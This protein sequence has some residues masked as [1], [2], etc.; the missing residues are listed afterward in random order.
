M[1]NVQSSASRGGEFADGT[2]AS[3]PNF[4][5]ATSQLEK[6]SVATN[7]VAFSC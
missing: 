7:P 2:V 1:S 5:A 3:S 4:S 6:D